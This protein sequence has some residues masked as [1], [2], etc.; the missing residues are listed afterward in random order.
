MER[1][2][3]KERRRVGAMRKG[4]HTG[5]SLEN[6]RSCTQSDVPMLILSGKCAMKEAVIF[7]LIPHISPAIHY[8]R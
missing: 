1:K 8:C 5:K 2:E 6:F 4:T 7:Y 3:E